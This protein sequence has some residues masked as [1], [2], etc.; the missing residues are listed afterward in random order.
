MKNQPVLLLSLVAALLTGGCSVMGGSSEAPV[1]Y[2][3]VTPIQPDPAWPRVTWRL[4]LAPATAPALIEDE[5]IMVSPTPGEL[6]LYRG[7]RWANAPTGMVEDAVLQTLEASEKIASV[8]RQGNGMMA[9]YRLLL[10][11]RSFRSDYAGTATPSALVEVNA[12]LLDVAAQRIVAD[13]S[14]RQQQAAAGTSV[15]Q[16]SEAFAQALGSIG[17]DIAGWALTM[18]DA[19]AAKTKP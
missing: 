9:D 6:Q 13:R 12:K 15:G 4:A 3:P 2:A 10:E 1:L 16:V 5:R 8:G 17:H 18:G 19:R 7:A 14:F 11:V